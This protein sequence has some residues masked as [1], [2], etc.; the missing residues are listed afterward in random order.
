VRARRFLVGLAVMTFVLP[1]CTSDDD[2]PGV[3]YEGPSTSAAI[4]SVLRDYLEAV[5]SNDYSTRAQLTTGELRTWNEWIAEEGFQ[6]GVEKSQ[7]TI[8]KLT[9]QSSRGREA[10]LELR[11]RMLFTSGKVVRLS[12][13]VLLRK[14][15]GEWRV[16]DYKRNGVSQRQAVVSRVRGRSRNGPVT[17]EALGWV[18]QDDYVDVFV[19]VEAERTGSLESHTARLGAKGGEVLRNGTNGPTV[20]GAMSVCIDGTGRQHRQKGIYGNPRPLDDDGAVTTDY[21]WAGKSLRDETVKLQLFT[22]FRDNST[23]K[24]FELALTMLAP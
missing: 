12:G 1:T 15:F 14:Q 21:Y 8:E 23:H 6:A 7:L 5:A 13:P 9:I 17:V 18:V 3:A 10:T 16:F 4:K 19:R 22:R 20:D 24:S 11:A 2:R